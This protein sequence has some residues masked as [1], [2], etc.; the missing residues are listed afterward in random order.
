MLKIVYTSAEAIKVIY[1]RLEYAPEVVMYLTV[2][3][4]IC[5]LIVSGRC[6]NNVSSLIAKL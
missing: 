2:V 4:I 6:K 5:V 1:S 3:V